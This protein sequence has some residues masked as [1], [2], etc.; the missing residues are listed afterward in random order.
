MLTKLLEIGFLTG[1]RAFGTSRE[2]SD[3]D[4]VYSIEDSQKVA[5]IIGDA[6]RSPSGYFA[7]YFVKDGN[8]QINLIPVHTHEYLPWYLA[9]KAMAVTLKQS[10][11]VDPIRKYSV[12]MG[13]VSLFKGTVEQRGPLSAYASVKEEI[14]N[15]F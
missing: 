12:F 1:S 15:S 10:G 6:E 8:K 2:D 9:T 3:Y 4:V 7:G 11:I 14:A 5:D 13:I